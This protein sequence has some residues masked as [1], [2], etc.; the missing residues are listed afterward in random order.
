MTM[1]ETTVIASVWYDAG[2]RNY[3]YPREDGHRSDWYNLTGG[4]YYYI[5]G[6]TDIEMS[7]AVEIRNTTNTI[8]SWTDE[9]C[10]NITNT[11]QVCIDEIV[12]VTTEVTEIVEEFNSTDNTT[13]NVTVTTNVTSNETVQNCT[14]YETIEELCENITTTTYDIP[15]TGHFQASKSIQQIAYEMDNVVEE[16]SYTVTNPDDGAY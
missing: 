10:G 4:E 11:E 8:N 6:A 13:V 9:V 1:P 12:E 2:W 16:W 5:K 14:D 3:F 7:V 15:Y